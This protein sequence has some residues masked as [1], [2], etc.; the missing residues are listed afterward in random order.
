MMITTQ[1]IPAMLALWEKNREKKVFARQKAGKI[2]SFWGNALRS[3][4]GTLELRSTCVQS[5]RLQGNTRLL[6]E[7]RTF[8]TIEPRRQT[9][10]VPRLPHS[11]DPSLQ[12]E[13]IDLVQK[14]VQGRLVQRT[15]RKRFT[16]TLIQLGVP[17][18]RRGDREAEGAALEMPFVAKAAT[19]VR[20]PPSPLNRN[21]VRQVITTVSAKVFFKGGRP[22][23]SGRFLA[24]LDILRL[25]TR[26]L[27]RLRRGSTRSWTNSASSR[28]YH[29]S[30]RCGVVLSHSGS[31]ACRICRQPVNDNRSTSRF[32]R[33]AASSISARTTKWPSDKAYNSC[34]TPA[35][36]WLRK[37]VG[38]VGHRGSWC[39]FCSSKTSSSAQRS[40]VVTRQFQSW[41]QRV[42]EQVGRQAMGLAMAGPFGII[43]R[44]LDHP[45]DDAVAILVSILRRGINL[46]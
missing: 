45:H 14:L 46:G 20:I 16:Q 5:N 13:R 1:Q 4:V 41:E 29:W 30:R 19:W 38:L 8:G 44:I 6:P 23:C 39:V 15:R 12:I 26:G 3:K 24:N 40:W 18:I 21:T 10:L 11:R 28:S 9:G 27:T 25:T 35:G 42:L 34:S 31:R 22:R 33:W 37:C 17:S 43:Q 2:G 7:R 36:V 32:S